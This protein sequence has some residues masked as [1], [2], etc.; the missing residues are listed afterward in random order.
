M[1][2]FQAF[3]P[4]KYLKIRFLRSRVLNRFVEKL[5]ARSPPL[6]DTLKKIDVPKSENAFL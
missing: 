6:I 5:D 3:Y 1:Q 2:C 4:I